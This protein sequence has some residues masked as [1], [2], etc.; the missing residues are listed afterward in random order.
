MIAILL[1]LLLSQPAAPVI[2][3]ERTACYGTCAIYKVSIFEDGKVLFEG[4]EFVR[5]QGKA[6]GRI[7]KTDLETL[8]REF[9]R[10]D[11]FKLGDRYEGE[12]NCPESWTDQPSAII[13]FTLNEIGRASCRERV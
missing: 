10:I 12:N 4:K 5:V 6:Q 11:F 2:T 1:A 3:L 7:S 8:Q 13:S 9:K